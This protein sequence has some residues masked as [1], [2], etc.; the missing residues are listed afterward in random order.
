MLEQVESRAPYSKNKIRMSAGEP[1][2]K[3]LYVSCGVE[4]WG[5]E[6]SSLYV[7]GWFVS[8]LS[9]YCSSIADCNIDGVRN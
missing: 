4:G 2:S 3:R 1:D 8:F 9:C 5:G 6:G 7:T